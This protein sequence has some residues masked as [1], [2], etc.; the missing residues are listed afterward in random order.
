M[1]VHLSCFAEDFSLTTF[2]SDSWLVN[3]VLCMPQDEPADS[4]HLTGRPLL[5]V[6]PGVSNGVLKCVRIQLYAMEHTAVSSTLLYSLL[7]HASSGRIEMIIQSEGSMW[8][9][10]HLI[11]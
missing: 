11:I 3:E 8:H 5:S 10:R 4:T 2:I 6:K 1:R 9:L 7:S